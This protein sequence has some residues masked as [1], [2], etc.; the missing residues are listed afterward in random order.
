MNRPRRLRSGVCIYWACHQHLLIQTDKLHL[1]ARVGQGGE[2]FTGSQL[3]IVG[4]GYLVGTEQTQR[5]S[6]ID[7]GGGNRLLP[8]LWGHGF[9]HGRHCHQRR[10]GQQ[11]RLVIVLLPEGVEGPSQP[12]KTQ[13]DQQV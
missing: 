9:Q 6:G 10:I 2:D 1:L 13:A 12:E 11:F 5:V 4:Q 7:I 3:A 8:L